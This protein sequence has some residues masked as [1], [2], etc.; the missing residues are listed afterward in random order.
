MND[1]N[2]SGYILVSD[3]PN[4]EC[5]PEVSFK[6]AGTI[7]SIYSAWFRLMVLLNEV[8]N[9]R[10]LFS[11]DTFCP[12]SKTWTT[13]ATPLTRYFLTTG[14]AI[15][16]VRDLS[17]GN[18]KLVVIHEATSKSDNANVELWSRSSDWIVENTF[19]WVGCGM[20]IP[21]R[22]KIQ[23]EPNR[24]WPKF[25]CKTDIGGKIAGIEISN[26]SYEMT[27]VEEINRNDSEAAEVSGITTTGRLLVSDKL[28]QAAVQGGFTISGE[29]VPGSELLQM[30]Y[31]CPS[32]DILTKIHLGDSSD[33]EFILT[34]S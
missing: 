31:T 21:R 6:V 8:P 16:K 18:E 33:C 30:P 24:L 1:I 11:T 13:E 34:T 27:W 2:D 10:A 12:D 17:D 14:I 19:R 28:T 15:F 9:I 25:S 22:V 29:I 26:S 32:F 7:E 23:L 20:R 3:T 4:V 5:N